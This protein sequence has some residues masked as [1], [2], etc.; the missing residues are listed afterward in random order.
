MDNK[1]RI[2]GNLTNII[3]HNNAALEG[4]L[5]CECGNPYF[6]IYHSGKQT[7]G[8][9][10]PYLINK[11][12]QISIEAKCICCGNSLTIYDNRL[13]GVKKFNSDIVLKQLLNISNDKCTFKL[14]LMYNYIKEHFKT[15]LFE[16][17]YIDISN[18]EFK[19]PRRLYEG[20]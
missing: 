12:K 17:C 19:K 4:D 2:I 8:I 13:D 1:L 5:I 7:K 3:E 14:H 6:K 11:N 9:L 18:S 15:N 20:C 10:A 16:E